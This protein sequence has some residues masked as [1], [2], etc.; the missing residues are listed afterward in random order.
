MQQ[1]HVTEK[2]LE[3]TCSAGDGDGDEWS[4]VVQQHQWK[5][6]NIPVRFFVGDDQKIVNEFKKSGQHRTI[7]FGTRILNVYWTAV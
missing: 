4:S 3:G 6:I 1:V 7:Q 5:E 2:G